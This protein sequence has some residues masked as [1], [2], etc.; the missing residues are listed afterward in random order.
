MI[1][2]FLNR[3]FECVGAVG[4]RLASLLMLDYDSLEES[5]ESASKTLE[6]G[7]RY[8]NGESRDLAEIALD[9]GNYMILDDGEAQ[10]L[11]T[12]VESEQKLNDKELEV[13]GEGGGIDLINDIVPAL[14]GKSNTSIEDYVEDAL[15]NTDFTVGLVELEGSMKACSF[16]EQTVSERLKAIAKEFDCEIQIEFEF[17]ELRLVS[18]KVNVFKVVGNDTGETISLYKDLSEITV[19]KS[20]SNMCT[21]ILPIGDGDITI[22]GKNYD[23]GDVYIDGKY[24]RSRVTAS[25]YG[26]YAKD[27]TIDPARHIT[28]K[29]SF[30]T[31]NKDDLLNLAVDEL[32]RLGKPEI[33]YEAEF[34]TLPQNVKVG[35]RVNLV[36]R[37]GNLYVSSRLLVIKKSN[38]KKT[39]EVTIGDHIIKNSG[40][41]D[42]VYELAE[43]FE[44]I[45]NNKPTFT[46]IA[47][48]DTDKGEGISLNQTGKAW[49]GIATN[50]ESESIDISDPSIFSWTSIEGRL[51]SFKELLVVKLDK[52]VTF[53]VGDTIP[54]A[55]AGKV[56]NIKN[57]ALI[58]FQA[59]DGETDIFYKTINVANV[60][61]SSSEEVFENEP[62]LLADEWEEVEEVEE[63]DGSD[64]WS[65]A[66]HW[67]KAMYGYVPNNNTI[68]RYDECESEVYVCIYPNDLIAS[69]TS[70]DYTI[71]KRT[72]VEG[73][74]PQMGNEVH[75]MGEDPNT[76]N[77]VEGSDVIFDVNI[78][79]GYFK[80]YY[81]KGELIHV[82]SATGGYITNS[83][84]DVGFTVPLAKPIINAKKITINDDR[85][86]VLVRQGGKYVYG[87]TSTTYA[88]PQ[89]YTVDIVNDGGALFV[90]AKMRNTT[91]AINNEACGIHYRFDLEIS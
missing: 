49:Q 43:R 8:E 89:S 47:Y 18:K 71:I 82:D 30:A 35:D 23:D 52:E 72:F 68:I 29:V 7:I 56:I 86:G 80:P 84:A 90:Y 65:W 88:K 58:G 62:M 37:K 2:Y 31:S 16:S 22:E 21:S 91:N 14:E 61:S 40:I 70:N 60:P 34:N 42:K 36:D 4:D 57:G 28:K 1:V 66:Y 27:N 6:L 87:S 24:L 77:Y 73:L 11:F 76:S 33:N 32:Y 83:G 25:T 69:N 63:E 3:N 50:M 45:A 78:S 20:I 44:Q 15:E 13:Y 38:T 55:I 67:T 10:E 51:T 39:V 48:A 75:L 74:A 19:K 64:N 5:V 41:S 53:V 81:T 17:D 26:R 46:W 54:S 85:G 79:D 9:V 59:D 12:I